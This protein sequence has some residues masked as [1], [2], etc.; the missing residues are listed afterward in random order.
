MFNLVENK[1]NL[2]QNTHYIKRQ[3]N[4]VSRMPSNEG[5]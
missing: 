2:I 5:Y 3:N 4:P 1:I